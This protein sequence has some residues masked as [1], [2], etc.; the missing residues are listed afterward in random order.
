MD[1]DLSF[2][3][4]IFLLK[5]QCQDKDVF[6]KYVRRVILNDPRSGIDI[7]HD[8]K[9]NLF[10]TQ[11]IIDF[12]EEIQAKMDSISEYSCVLVYLSKYIENNENSP[13][14]IHNKL[15]HEYIKQ[16][17]KKNPEELEDTDDNPELKM[18]RQQFQ[19]FLKDNKY[20]TKQ[21]YH[22]LRSID[23]MLEE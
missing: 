21:I 20:D 6:L 4:T 1:T 7:F 3:R 5:N 2:K 17:K 16:L 15:A 8:L 13:P 23:W 22:Q 18:L 10:S 9:Y 11:E 19:E 14:S 12:L